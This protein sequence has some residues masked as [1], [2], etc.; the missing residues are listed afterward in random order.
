MAT[1]MFDLRLLAC[2]ILGCGFLATVVAF[3]NT[4]KD[5]VRRILLLPLLI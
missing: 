3:D 1:R 2:L 4:R 5:N